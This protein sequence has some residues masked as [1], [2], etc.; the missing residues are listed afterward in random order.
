ME[1]PRG[2]VDR[3]KRRGAYRILKD[4]YIKGQVEEMDLTREN[5]K[6]CPV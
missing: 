1:S 2:L 3:V 5:I 4:F 6:E